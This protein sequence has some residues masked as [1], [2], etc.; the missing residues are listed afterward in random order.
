MNLKKLGE[1]KPDTKEYILYKCTFMMFKNGG[2]EPVRI[3][4]RT[5]VPTWSQQCKK[6]GT[7]TSWSNDNASILNQG[8]VYRVNALVKTH[9]S[10][11]LKT[12][13]L[14]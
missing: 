6:R 10:C 12:C 13:A 7:R 9:Q 14:I 2:N 11:T 8:V 1:Q 5:M 4:I 3:K